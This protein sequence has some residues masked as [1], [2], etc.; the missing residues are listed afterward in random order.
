MMRIMVIAL[1]T[2]EW[3][4]GASIIGGSG[5]WRY[6]YM[7]ELLQLPQG[8]QVQ[9]AHGLELDDD[10]NILLTYTNWNNH[11]EGVQNGTDANC[12]IRWAPDGTGGAFLTGG[13][14]ALCDGKPHGL[15]LAHEGGQ[16]FLYHSNVDGN[17][18]K[19]GAGKLTKTTLD[20]TIVWQLNGTFGQ[21]AG[22]YRPTWWA[23]HEAL[24]KFIYLADGYG[25]SRVYVFTR[26]GKWTGRA[27]G[28]KGAAHG[29]FNQCHGITYDPRSKQLAVAD[30]HNSRIEFFDFNAARGD[31]FAYAK[32]VNASAERLP[33]FLP[34]NFRVLQ[35]A[36][37]PALDGAAVV[38]AL[39]GPVAI[40]NASNALV[41]V[42]DVAKLI[43]HL[44]SK[45]PHDAVFLRNGDLVVATWNP[46]YVSYWRRLPPTPAAAPSGR[47]RGLRRTTTYGQTVK[48]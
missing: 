17:G 12:L 43:G 5:D 22:G 8:A 38:P 31:T 46:G 28:G 35:G 36:T 29:L 45:H 39:E 2:L 26:D 37:L 7:P 21:A 47:G 1:A 4:Q 20:G 44:G 25:S 3:V 32:T 14:R 16:S 6:Q 23:V 42:V 11:G 15:K 9:D 19:L 24:G 40:F 10:G 33:G 41:S 30:R 34:C 27:F 48:R 18:T 13:G